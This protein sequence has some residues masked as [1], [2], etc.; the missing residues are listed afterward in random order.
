M[1]VETKLVITLNKEE[2]KILDEAETVLTNLSD[3]LN[4]KGFS[5]LDISEDVDNCLDLLGGI[6]YFV[7]KPIQEEP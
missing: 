6:L 3:K 5:S 7:Q 1:T 4:K 2:Y